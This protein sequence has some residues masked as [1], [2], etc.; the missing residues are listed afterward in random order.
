MLI[1]NADD[2][3]LTQIDNQRI[4]DAA[5]FGIIKSTTIV[6]NSVDCGAL[7]DIESRDISTGLHINLVEGKPLTSCHSLV[8]NGGLFLRKRDLFSNIALRKVNLSELE[9]EICAQFENILDSGLA[10]THVDSHQNTHIFLPLLGI[11]TKLAA[12]YKVFRIRGQSSAYNWFNRGSEARTTFK[13]ALSAAWNLKIDRRFKSTDRVVLN[14]PGLGCHVCS[15]EKATEMWHIALLRNYQSNVI[16]EVPCHL[17]LS[18]FEYELYR[19]KTMAEMFN[20]LN[21]VVGNYRDF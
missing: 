21:I 4:L 7:K 5:L 1:F 18:D 12:K 20:T 8:D 3:G 11:I 9:A 17:H 2:F 14:A 19:S 15:I 6:S 13:F 16:Y 10:I